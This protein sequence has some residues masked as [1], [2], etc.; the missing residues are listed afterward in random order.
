MITP[1][2]L[3]SEKEYREKLTRGY[4]IEENKRGVVELSRFSSDRTETI[5]PL[6]HGFGIGEPDQLAR[7]L[8]AVII[9]DH[10]EELIRPVDM[11]IGDH[12]AISLSAGFMWSFLMGEGPIEITHRQINN[13]LEVRK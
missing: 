11:I 12:P 8:A 2:D 7:E 9:C 4:R 13:Y 3:K 10:L 1:Y 6:Q 5:S